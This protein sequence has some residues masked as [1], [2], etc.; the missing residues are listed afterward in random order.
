[1]PS[2]IFLSST[3]AEEWIGASSVFSSAAFFALSSGFCHQYPH[4]F[5]QGYDQLV[6]SPEVQSS[7]WLMTKYF[8]QCIQELP[9]LPTSSSRLAMFVLDF[10]VFYLK[11]FDHFPTLLSTLI[12]ARFFKLLCKF[13]KDHLVTFIPF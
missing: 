7:C 13:F 4:H 11:L 12:T 8:I 6:S 2:F 5:T 9:F 3:E 10:S 1:M